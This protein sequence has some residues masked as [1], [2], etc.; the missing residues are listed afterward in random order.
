[1]NISGDP[2]N[3][4]LDAFSRADAPSVT[5]TELVLA[6]VVAAALSVPRRSWRYFGLLATATHEMGHAVAALI[7][8]Q[9]LSGIRLRLDHSGTTTT[10]SRSRLASAWSCFWGYPV[11]AIVGATFV[12]CG[13]NGWGPAAIMA[14]SLALAAS[15][16]FL[17][18]LAGILITVTA[19]SAS[20]LLILLV[21]EAFVGHVAVILGVALLVAAVRDLIKL[22]HLHLR[23]RERLA[24]SDAYLLWRAT[25]V[26]SGVWII[27]FAALVAGSWLWAW[28]PISTVLYAGA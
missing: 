7:S 16:L 26:P 17:R 9:R 3:R 28:Q 19:M 14:G 20:V 4:L 2:W 8:G 27:L 12:W 13:F 24:S 22:A 10:Y 18:N 23:R 1:M 21:P 5:L 11:P 6:L 15:L 25:S